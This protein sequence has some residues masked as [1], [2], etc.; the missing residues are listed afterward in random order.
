MDF[1]LRYWFAT[2]S[3]PPACRFYPSYPPPPHCFPFAAGCVWTTAGHF[4][5]FAAPHAR[6]HRTSR[7]LTHHAPLRCCGNAICRVCPFSF[8]TY[9][10]T[11]QHNVRHALPVL[12]WISSTACLPGRLPVLPTIRLPR[13]LTVLPVLPTYPIP[14]F[15]FRKQTGAQRGL[16]RHR[17]VL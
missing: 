9:G 7:L 12:I 1:G 15:P 8:R 3:V 11:Q 14:P 2:G 6:Y 16:A 13:G 4:P 5:A 10:T 17:C